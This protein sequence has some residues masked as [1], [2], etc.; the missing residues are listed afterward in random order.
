MKIMILIPPVGRRSHARFRVAQLVSAGRKLGL[1]IF[2]KEV[3]ARKRDRYSFFSRLPGV[4]VLV[5]YR[6]FFSSYELGNLRRLCSTMIY[7]CTD[8]AWTLP[9]HERKVGSGLMLS[10][11]SRRFMRV[12]RAV[13]FC[14]VDNR[15][16]AEVVSQYTQDVRI[17]PTPIDTER[18]A[19][20]DG[21]KSGGVPLVGWMGTP[22]DELYLQDA[23]QNLESSAGQIQFS[24]VSR[25][26][27]SGPGQEF[28]FWNMWSHEAE[29]RL[30]QAMDI[31]VLPM[32]ETG[33]TRSCSGVDVLKFMASGVAIVASD[34][35]VHREII[36]HG[37]DGFLVQNESDWEES[38][39]R[40]A[41]DVDLRRS[42]AENA[43]R[44]AV[45][46][47]SLEA[48]APQFWRNFGI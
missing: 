35:G 11:L 44:K 29:P 23:M 21:G 46:K 32:P 27:Y 45:E 41:E 13:D 18:Y 39:I 20:G 16:L 25:E 4:D 17:I 40:L 12:C 24:V 7:D 5:L 33:F 36:D 9:E 22:G 48:I 6:E 47:Y 19:P 3:P 28:V 8:A 14:L 31:G 37:V 2:A 38:V 34:V 26:P 42:I 1:D 30:L 43:R 10:K 15:A